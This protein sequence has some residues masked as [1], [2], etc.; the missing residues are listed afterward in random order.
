MKPFTRMS[1]VLAVSLFVA[2]VLGAVAYL[3]A[4][5]QEAQDLL[6]GEEEIWY[7]VDEDGGV[8][9]D[10]YFF[11]SQTCP[12]CRTAHP[13]ILSLPEELPW[14]R[15]HTLELNQI[16]ENA[17]L[18]VELAQ[19]V[20]QEAMYVPAFIYCGTMQAGYDKHETT[21]AAIR[22]DLI[23]CQ[24]Q[25]QE[26][27]AA[28]SVQSQ[29]SAES[30]IAE[31]EPVPNGSQ[32]AAESA[33][34]A[35][36]GGNPGPAPSAAALSA[37]SQNETISVPLLGQISVASLSLPALTFLIAGVDSINPCAIFVL[38]FLLSLMVHAQS[39]SRM[40]LI[41]IVFVLFSG[42]IYFVFMSAWLNIFLLV[43]E[44]R[45]ITLVAGL[46]AIVI[47]LI[48][49]KDFFW[50][51]QGVS[52]SIPES[53]KPGLYARTR[54]LV[55]AGSLGAMLA[56]TALLAIAANS[57]ELLCTAGFPMVY[58]RIL[59]MAELPTLTYYTYLAAYN[60]IYVIPLLTIVV[61]FT[62]FLGSRKLG[63][64]EGRALKLV[65]GLMMLMLGLVLVFAPEELSNMAVSVGLILAAL[66]LAVT[67]IFIDRRRQQRR[68]VGRTRRARAS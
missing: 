14:L 31:G 22:Q 46:V 52:L 59:T 18:Y 33:A 50:Y 23:N 51:K 15:L 5:A 47:A 9:I 48:N 11:W 1:V 38:M 39:R 19:L 36:T 4:Q 32:D 67:I 3:P 8:N 68:P 25:L 58:T 53:A 24:A 6:P 16:P 62:V 55:Q 65:S 54:N 7:S 17:N 43:G 37:A 28:G 34:S 10:L 21:G 66:V 61:L 56:S 27:I 57:Y 26:T 44:L 12:H 63:E 45:I 2:V 40:L 30:Q 41:G 60:I 13:Y 35:T 64:Q 29:G 42:L 20:G 49:I